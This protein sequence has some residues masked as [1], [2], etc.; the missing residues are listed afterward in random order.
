MSQAAVDAALAAP[1]LSQAV[2]YRA[3]HKP[4][5]MAAAF[6]VAAEKGNPVAELQ[7]AQLYHAGTDL[8]QDDDL[9]DF[10]LRKS[11]SQG[12]GEAQV[13]LAESFFARLSK[14][15]DAAEG[16]YWLHLAE[17]QQ[18]P[19]IWV[20]IGQVYLTGVTPPSAAEPQTVSDVIE[21][22]SRA[23]DVTK[24]LQYFQKAA[25]AGDENG[26]LALCLFYMKG[27]GGTAPSPKDGQPWCDRAASTGN[28]EARKYSAA[29]AQLPPPLPSPD[30]DSFFVVA[31][32]DIGDGVII[33]VYVAVD[34]LAHSG[35]F[36]V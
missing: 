34:V 33:L 19:A 27:Q 12:L 31:L 7:L 32:Q 8:Q 22:T 35:G 1:E 15:Q 29:S 24:A 4:D 14:T 10:W 18:R 5:A 20:M 28:I 30:E 6:Q 13:T 26:A 21:D 17:G 3:Q 9:A 25:K 36:H 23:P 2:S 16:W 11:A